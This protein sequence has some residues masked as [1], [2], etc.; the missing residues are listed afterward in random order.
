MAFDEIDDSIQK[1][2]ET[3]FESFLV[4]YL[5]YDTFTGILSYMI[6]YCR[7]NFLVSIVSRYYSSQY[8]GDFWL[9]FSSPELWCTDEMRY[10]IDRHFSSIAIMIQT[11]VTQVSEHIVD[12]HIL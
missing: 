11:Y 5:G 9:F 7:D 10:I 8:S 2:V 6:H 4:E 1:K 3:I 12:I